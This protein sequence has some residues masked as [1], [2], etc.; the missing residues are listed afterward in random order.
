M[1]RNPDPRAE[2]STAHAADDPFSVA[3]PLRL[4]TRQHTMRIF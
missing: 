2:G 4:V 3:K 1:I